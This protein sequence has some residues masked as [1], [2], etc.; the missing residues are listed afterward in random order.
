MCIH[1]QRSAV[2]MWIGAV[3]VCLTKEEL[4]PVLYNL[5]APLVREQELAQGETAQTALASL[6]NEVATKLKKKVGVDEY[7]TCA[8]KLQSQLFKKRAERKATQAQE[9]TTAIFVLILKLYALIY[10]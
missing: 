8:L 7:A 4:L 3:A 5:A 6:A 9:V 2:F 1:F 10:F